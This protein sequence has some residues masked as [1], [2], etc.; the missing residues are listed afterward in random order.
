MDKEGINPAI[1]PRRNAELDSIPPKVGLDPDPWDPEGKHQD[2]VV[3]AQLQGG[4]R[5]RLDGGVLALMGI[6]WRANFVRL[7]CGRI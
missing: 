4:D 6:E 5:H 2:P 3:G 7:A 1:D